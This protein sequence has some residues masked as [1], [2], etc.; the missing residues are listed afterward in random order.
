MYISHFELSIRRMQDI[1]I[2]E[3]EYLLAVATGEQ[4]WMI[5]MSN[6]KTFLPVESVGR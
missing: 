4:I 3:L 5:W 2:I 6:L 1:T